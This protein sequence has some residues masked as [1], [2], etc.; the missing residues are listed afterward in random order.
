MDVR[1]ALRDAASEAGWSQT[2]V[3]ATAGLTEGAIRKL[4]RG[5]TKSLNG[6]ALLA[7]MES[8]PGFA[9]RLGY[10]AVRRAA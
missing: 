4:E 10:R 3:A 5:D 8:L 6:D 2:R 9:E 1:T 7:L